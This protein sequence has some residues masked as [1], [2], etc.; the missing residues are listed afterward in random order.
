MTKRIQKGTSGSS[1]TL[2]QLF[3]GTKGHVPRF[4][5]ILPRQMDELVAQGYFK[6][7]GRNPHG[8]LNYKITEKG[9]KYLKE[10]EGK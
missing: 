2:K 8:K 10:L 6:P 7:D 5:L 9:L 3:G 1:S 4:D